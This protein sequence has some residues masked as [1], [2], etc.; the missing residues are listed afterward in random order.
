LTPIEIF[1]QNLLGATSVTLPGINATAE[2]FS[3]R[4]DSWLSVIF[5]RIPNLVDPITTKVVINTPL[6]S[7]SGYP[8]Y[9]YVPY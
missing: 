3:K 6:Y 7:S 9:L 5:P 8:E 1:G 4:S 2:I